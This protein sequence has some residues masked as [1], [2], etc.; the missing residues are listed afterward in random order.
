MSET[1]KMHID[2]GVDRV[3]TEVNENDSKRLRRFN[4]GAALLHFVSSM[5]IF[6]ITDKDAASPVYTFYANDQRGNFSLYGPE[7]E[8]VGNAV[9]GYFAAVFLL[10]A[11]LDHLIVA[12]ILRKMYENQLR[13]S[14]NLIRWFEYSFSAALMHVMIAMLSGV[15]SLHLLLAIFGLTMATMVFGALQELMTW[16]FQGSPHKKTLL[17]FWLGCIPH[18]FG[19]CIIF[20]YFFDGVRRG[21][22]PAFV[23]AIVPI[24]FIID[25]SFA[26]N[27]FLQQKEFGKWR[28]YLYGE[29]AFTILSFTAKSLLAWINFGGTN[30]LKED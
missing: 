10:L 3:T 1:Q 15:M 6:G 13:H 29:Y 5:A 11:F 9:I 18:M 14:M 25:A 4:L 26:V 28:N 2:D 22:P 12:T 17:P 24:E 23:W 8:L 30:T 27:M 20:S 19:W 21:D 7:P 16:R